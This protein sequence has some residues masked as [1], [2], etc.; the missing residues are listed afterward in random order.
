MRILATILRGLRRATQAPSS[1]T[2]AGILVADVPSSFSSSTLI[3]QQLRCPSVMQKAIECTGRHRC[4]PWLCWGSD[5]NK[6]EAVK[7]KGGVWDFLQPPPWRR[8]KCWGHL[9]SLACF[10]ITHR[11]NSPTRPPPQ[12]H[13]PFQAVSYQQLLAPF[14]F[15]GQPIPTIRTRG[16]PT[17]ELKL[18]RNV[19]SIHLSGPIEHFGA[20]SAVLWRSLQRGHL[21]RVQQESPGGL[22]LSKT[23][24]EWFRIVRSLYQAHFANF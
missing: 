14:Q 12:P 4:C 16:S 3:P 17:A 9:G 15:S 19:P 22:E 20:T 13:Q 5:F 7:V 24:W 11:T 23:I 18:H 21:G 8:R 6:C 10:S 2:P 1:S